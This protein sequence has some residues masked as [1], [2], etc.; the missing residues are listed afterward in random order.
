MDNTQIL[1]ALAQG[2]KDRRD[3]L[4]LKKGTVKEREGQLNYLI[5]AVKTLEMLGKSN[6]GIGFV[7]LLVSTGRDICDEYLPKQ[8]TNAAQEVAKAGA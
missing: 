5:G 6:A 2:W 3:A 1:Q 8:K 4:P 7:T